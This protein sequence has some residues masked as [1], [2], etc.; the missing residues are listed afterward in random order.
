MPDFKCVVAIFIPEHSG[1]KVG[2]AGSLC[3]SKILRRPTNNKNKKNKMYSKFQLT[4]YC[5]CKI[6]QFSDFKRE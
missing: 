4:T 6:S 1:L 5:H 2:V 3:A